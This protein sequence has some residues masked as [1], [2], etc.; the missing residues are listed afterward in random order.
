MTDG[1]QEM[2]YQFT[3]VASLSSGPSIGVVVVYYDDQPG[4]D[5]VLTALE[6]SIPGSA[7][8]AAPDPVP[9]DRPA[10]RLQ[11][12]VADDGSPSAPVLGERPYD[13]QLVRQEDRGFRAAAARNLG[14]RTLLAAGVDLLVFLD[15]DT[16]PEPGFLAELTRALSR[17][18]RRA[19]TG[20]ALAVGR[21]RHVDFGG[22]DTRASI[23]LITALSTP[24]GADLGA[25]SSIPASTALD[26]NSGAKSPNARLLQDPAWLEQGYA[27]T[28][29]LTRP[30]DRSYRFVL[31][32]VLA[33]TR[34]LFE[35]VDGFDE[36]FVGYGGEDWDLANRCYLAGADFAYARAA[37][38]WHDGPDAGHRPVPSPELTATPASRETLRLAHVI[39]EPGAR[40]PRLIWEI[41]DIAVAVDDR[42]WSVEET[43]LTCADLIQGSD[44]R[45]WLRDGLAVTDGV[46]PRDDPRVAIGEVPERVLARARYR[47]TVTRPLR[48]AL[49]LADVC[50]QGE[51]EYPGL[52]VRRTRNLARG[53]GAP[54]GTPPPA[55]GPAP[56]VTPTRTDRRLE[57]EWGWR[58]TEPDRWRRQRTRSRPSALAPI[59]RA[60]S[61]HVAP[62]LTGTTLTALAELLTGPAS[63]APTP[64][65]RAHVE[66]V[67]V[68]ANPLVGEPPCYAT[69]LDAGLARLTGFEPQPE[70]L[71][72]LHARARCEGSTDRFFGVAVGDGGDHELRICAEAGFSSLLE[73]D[74][75]QLCT[76]TDFPRLAAVTDR[77]QVPTV[78]LDDLTA[79][80]HADLLTLDAQGNE[81]SILRHAH[82]LLAG[83][84]AVQVEVPFYRI[85]AGAPG[86]AEVDL[87][88]RD[89]GFVPH[90]F[91]T[92]RT[93]P[94]A[95][96][97][98]ADPLET[99]SRQLVEADLL[100]VRD[101]ARL[102]ALDEDTLRTGILVAAG[103]YGCLGLGLVLLRE[104]IRRGVLAPE[105]ESVYRRLV[106]PLPRERREATN[107]PTPVSTKTTTNRP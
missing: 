85:Y 69:L 32:A 29:D 61:S 31:S 3:G 12:V 1:N 102:E 44:T 84:V 82:R 40:D 21:R 104:A 2:N 94:L 59:N 51:G 74:P 71:A 55:A 50:A 78:R 35:A 26:A 47:V 14:A 103:A 42:G 41:P 5:R 87:T 38:A 72:A 91:V 88:L 52:G 98:W 81:L 11:V 22:L 8:A 83:A 75:A 53:A 20:R 60:L 67:D 92:T 90:T 105:A 95:P 97:T 68:G 6:R 106:A 77:V 15:G 58:R 39:T 25:T 56:G 10:L 17:T 27:A 80:A 28:G 100:Y 86:F 99:H 37:V 63:T 23:D 76:L 43:L 9:A 62:A 24:D 49:P 93:W 48:L 36:S 4:L 89:A 46:W 66:I 70:A 64:D 7:R 45:V 54:D 101:P 18:A 19:P 96:V 107:T 73:P 13:V 34:E 57:A 65:R 33:M 30:D 16:V 79:I